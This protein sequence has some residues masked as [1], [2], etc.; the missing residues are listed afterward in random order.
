[1]IRRNALSAQGLL[2]FASTDRLRSAFSSE[3]SL[4]GGRLFSILV[5]AFCQLKSRSSLLTVR[6]T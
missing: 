1:M 5:T 6:R 3:V 4:G 2:S